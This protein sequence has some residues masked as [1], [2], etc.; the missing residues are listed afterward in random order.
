MT[1]RET[2]EGRLLHDLVA[3][4]P[5]AGG[6]L[7]DYPCLREAAEALRAGRDVDWER[8]VDWSTLESIRADLD[9]LPNQQES[10][11]S[12]FR[13]PYGSGEPAARIF[14]Q[15]RGMWKIA[16]GK[17]MFFLQHAIG[18]FYMC[19]LMRQPGKMISASSLKIA[20]TAWSS[21]HEGNLS[22]VAK[23]SSLVTPTTIED[24]GE[25]DRGI[26]SN[27][28]D[29]GESL[30]DEAREA[31]RARILVLPEEIEAARSRGM[32]AK[33]NEL[34]DEQTQLLTILKASVDVHGRPRRMSRKSNRDRDSVSKAIQRSMETIGV[35]IPEFHEHLE[36]SLK[37]GAYCVYSPKTPT[38]WET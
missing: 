6:D 4:T 16:F 32:L 11:R 26:S 21:R 5:C 17:E 7:D 2:P 1:D 22:F 29:R 23:E 12:H 37:L 8:L 3:L 24:L 15:F 27:T 19:E 38:N 28:L 34:A 13:P 18:H 33:A 20:H 31:Y 9:L 25:S 35:A 10:S 30:D 14:C 36:S